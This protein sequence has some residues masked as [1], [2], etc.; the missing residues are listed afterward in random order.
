MMRTARS[1]T[2]SLTEAKNLKARLRIQL[3]FEDVDLVSAM[4]KIDIFREETRRFK[5][6]GTPRCGVHGQRSA[7]SLPKA[8]CE[9][10]S[11]VRRSARRQ[12]DHAIARLRAMRPVPCRFSTARYD[13]R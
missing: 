12:N 3:G 11:D 13:L 8:C 7:L 6:V 1:T 9:A 4:A 2:A 5:V 10:L